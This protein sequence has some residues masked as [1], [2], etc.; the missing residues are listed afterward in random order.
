MYNLRFKCSDEE[1]TRT[2][3]LLDAQVYDE[4][5]ISSEP[6]YEPIHEPLVKRY[7]RWLSIIQEM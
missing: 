1:N 2:C 6:V 7:D 4:E 3:P 5:M